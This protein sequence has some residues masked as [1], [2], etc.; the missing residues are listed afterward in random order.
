[1]AWPRFNTNRKPL[2]TLVPDASWV[3]DGGAFQKTH[4]CGTWSFFIA[5]RLMGLA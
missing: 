5:L 3:S 1:V 2:L 4:L